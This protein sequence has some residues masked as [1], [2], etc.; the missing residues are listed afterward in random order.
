MLCCCE[1]RRT[2]IVHLLQI[3]EIVYVAKLLP[4]Y[5]IRSVKTSVVGSFS[6]CICT[7]LTR[8]CILGIQLRRWKRPGNTWRKWRTSRI[9]TDVFTQA[10]TTTAFLNIVIFGILWRRRCGGIVVEFLPGNRMV[11]G[12]N[13]T[14]PTAELPWTRWGRAG[15]FEPKGHHG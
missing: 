9:R 5:L 8:R 14:L 3:F 13:L 15:S 12:S 1:A 10:T 11:V 4:V 7:W 6:L 2:F